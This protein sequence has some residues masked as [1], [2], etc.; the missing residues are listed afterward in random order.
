MSFTLDRL[1]GG[2]LLSALLFGCSQDRL[3]PP[4]HPPGEHLSVTRSTADIPS[5]P[6][7]P[8][9]YVRGDPGGTPPHVAGVVRVYQDEQPWTNANRA[10]VTLLEI[11]KVLGEDYF[12][13]PLID[14]QAGIPPGTRLVIITSNSKGEAQQRDRQNHPAAQAALA[15]FLRGGGH[16]IVD[17]GDN[18][19]NGG[20]IAPGATGTPDRIF[21]D[22][23]LCSRAFLTPEAQGHPFRTAWHTITDDDVR[24]TL[25]CYI[26]HGNLQQGITLPADHTRLA[27]A[28]FG[29]IP[30][31]VMAEYCFEGRGRV[32]LETLTKEFSGW[33]PFT[34]TPAQWGTPFMRNLFAYGL[35]EAAA[36]DPPPP[37]V[38]IHQVYSGLPPR[39]SGT[40][41]LEDASV[42]VEI[43]DIMSLGWSPSQERPGVGDVRLG[44]SFETG[45]PA[46]W[47]EVRD[48]NMDGKLDVRLRWSLPQLI[49]HGHLGPETTRIEVWGRNPTTGEIFRGE[50]E[51]EI[52]GPDLVVL[53]NNGPF[54]THPGAGAGG[55]D[56]SMASSGAHDELGSNVRHA[57]PA[58]HF[59]L[60]DDFT[61][62]AGGWTVRR[63][64]TYGFE[65]DFAVPNW[66]RANLNLRSGSAEGPI[67][68]SATTTNWQWSGVY[69]V[70]NGL[71]NLGN[72]DRPIYEIRF[73]F[74]DLEL[75]PGTYWI[76]WQVEGGFGGWGNYVMQPPLTPGGA[77]TVTV[78]GNGRWLR[79][80]TWHP[81]LTAPGAEIP[82][83][84]LGAGTPASAP[85]AD[86]H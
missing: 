25:Y 54:V 17:M 24:N 4:E 33:H 38:Q 16:L 50:A 2:V 76:D 73:N 77:N 5:D 67:V 42:F 86:R 84:V 36:C 26:A 48:L 46:E 32:I 19:I 75:A 72:S 69:R 15:D 78:L 29:G 43:L 20:F 62:P 64:V 53:W 18:L 47:F 49:D 37:G 1:F 34:P 23:D 59:R 56:V 14:L 52:I 40:I 3:T 13:H 82:F 44:P 80:G 79:G 57:P 63:V 7:R 65:F 35:S 58:P 61:V 70:H 28:I 51:V 81:T 83:K 30:R 71:G 8:P 66:T 12:I 45:T 74:T 21:P 85:T 60:A 22:P 6:H 9:E 10:H 41:H 39:A 27:V 31:L 55:A 11:G 68:A